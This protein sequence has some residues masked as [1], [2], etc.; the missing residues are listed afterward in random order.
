MGWGAALLVS[1]LGFGLFVVFATG[2]DKWT[3]LKSTLGGWFTR[4]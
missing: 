1:S 4:N 2:A 3:R